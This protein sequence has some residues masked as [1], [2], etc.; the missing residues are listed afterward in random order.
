MLLQGNIKVW[1]LTVNPKSLPQDVFRK[2]ATP[3]RA[4]L[5][6][7]HRH[8]V[9]CLMGF[10]RDGKPC[11]FSGSDDTTAKVMPAFDIRSSAVYADS[12][13]VLCTDVAGIRDGIGI[14]QLSIHRTAP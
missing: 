3:P 6:R 13:G 8:K 11:L 7:Y 12:R 5:L 4:M 14:L 1:P 10:L 9:N 2:A